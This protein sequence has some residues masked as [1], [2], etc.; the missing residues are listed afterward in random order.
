MLTRRAETAPLLPRPVAAALGMP[1]GIAAALLATGLGGG[2][3]T[4]TVCAALA[5]LAIGCRA[6]V[7][8]AAGA[9]VLCWAFVDGFVLHRF[10]E[11][12]AGAPDL[13]ALAVVLAAGLSGSLTAGAV[14]AT[15]RRR[16]SYAALR[17]VPAARAVIGHRVP[18]SL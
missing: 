11:L 7:T 8:G 18:R 6:P 4:G 9:A 12:H 10:G 17:A 16:R 5:A 13:V 1:A 14:R 15:A 3:A 2:P